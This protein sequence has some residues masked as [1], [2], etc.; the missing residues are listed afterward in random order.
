MADPR[1]EDVLV[2]KTSTARSKIVSVTSRL[3][4]FKFSLAW[5]FAGSYSAGAMAPYKRGV[6]GSIPAAPTR[7]SSRFTWLHVHVWV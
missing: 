7:R 6:A 3:S 2:D 4:G 5:V 1:G